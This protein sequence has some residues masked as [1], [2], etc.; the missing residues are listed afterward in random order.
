MTDFKGTTVLCVK[1]DGK[2]A[3]GGDGQVTLGS[4][5]VKSKAKKV[6]EIIP[7]K[8][9]AG[10]AGSTADA[11][12]LFERLEAK[13]KDYNYNLQ[14]AAVELAKDWRMD[15]SLRR[16]E[17][18]LLAVDKEHIFLMSGTGDVIE[19]DEN[20]I[21]IG[22]GSMAAQAAAL[23]LIKHTQLPAKQIVEE[24]LKIASKLCIYTNDTFV[25]EEL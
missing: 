9:I 15:K 10:F 23:S 21:S 17:A 25:I 20:I 16:L 22:S 8:V 1:R 3:L 7:G 19:P 12:T 13:L 18:L 14:R 2:I 5:I 6:R 24:S 4:T 11:L